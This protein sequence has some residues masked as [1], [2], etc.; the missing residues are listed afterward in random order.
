MAVLIGRSQQK[1]QK[2]NTFENKVVVITGGNSG[3][4]LATAKKFA[5]QGAKV[6]ISGR[7]PET[8][9]KA[10]NEIGNSTLAVQADV[11]K[12]AD[13]DRLFQQVKT[14]FGGIDVLFANAGVA[15]FQPVGDVTV[16]HYDE[17]LNTNLKGAY[18]T[19]QKALPLLNNPAAIVL[20]TTAANRLGLPQSTVYAASKAAL[21]SLARTL[22][23]ELVGRGIR[24][25]AVA[26]G[27]IETPI[28]G[29]LGM[30]PQ[31]V[32]QL[33]TAIV[34]RVP[35]KRIGKP[36]EIADAVLFLAS[37]ASSYITGSELNVD[38]GMTQL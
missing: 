5:A 36:E 35:Q 24:V 34:G 23:A 19:I 15:K 38:G 8:L 21:R 11:T 17:L 10:G 22:S 3:I 6:V 26:P 9:K 25:N 32:E 37:P 28:F 16:E 4:G 33:A 14:R 13:L 1:K 29:R 12:L 18:F 20:T 7:D 2:M 31:E 30:K 27:P